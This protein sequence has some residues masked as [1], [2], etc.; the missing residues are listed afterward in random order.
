MPKPN[1]QE[2][3]APAPVTPTPSAPVTQPE[4][5]TWTDGTPFD[6]KRAKELLTKLET[7]AK[8]G[9]KAVKRLAELEAKEKERADAELSETEKLKKQLA[10]AQAVNDRLAREQM[11]NKV[12]AKVG[13]PAVFANRIQGDTEE[14]MEEDARSLLAAMPAKV[15]PPLNPTNPGQPQTGETDADRRERLGLPAAR[16]K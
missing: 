6:A 11:Q 10:D 5:E 15:A 16:R 13:L 3:Q 4:I 14:L 7:E 12:A 8:E 9:K 2:G 1:E